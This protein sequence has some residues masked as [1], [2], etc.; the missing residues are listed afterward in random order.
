M[1]TNLLKWLSFTAAIFVLLP[2]SI[3]LGPVR[4]IGACV[5]IGLTIVLAKIE[6]ME[7]PKP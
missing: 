4:W 1:F 6:G 5:L 2:A 3:A 7:M